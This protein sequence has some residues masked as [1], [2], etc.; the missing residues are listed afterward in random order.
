MKIAHISDLHISTKM[1]RRNI[2]NTYKLLEHLLKNNYDH[3]VITGDITENG[4]RSEF[5]MMRKVLSEF[6][7]LDAKKLSMVIGNHDIFGGVQY[8]EDIVGF[9][10]K[11]RKID[12]IEKLQEFGHY[13]SEIFEGV[14]SPTGDLF[15]YAKDL[16]ETV[17]VGVNSISKYSR[18]NNL[19]S[20]NGKISHSQVKGLYDIFNHK[21]YLKYLKR[22]LIVMIHHH[23]YKIPFESNTDAGRLW[24]RIENQTMKLKQRKKFLNFIS[25]YNVKLV[26]HGHVHE[27]VEYFKKGMKCMN[28][29]QTFSCS[30]PH[31][32]RYNSVIVEDAD[33]IGT[34]IVTINAKKSAGAIK[35]YPELLAVNLS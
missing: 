17:L 27:S 18:I 32:I 10:Q 26:L 30:S 16:D 34:D 35:Q 33:T 20:S 12:Y 15:P 2:K 19:F 3:I 25:R 28:G 13:F 24:S 9:P 6:N 8:A 1:K 22:P 21:K 4:T 7:L 23:L 11:C 5:K 31:K 29:G 14:H